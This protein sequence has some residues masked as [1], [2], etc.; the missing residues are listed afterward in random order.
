MCEANDTFREH[1]VKEG[2]QKVLYVQLMKALYGCVK[3]AL[4]WYRLYTEVLQ[5]MGFILNPYNQCVANKE[6][7]GSQCTVAFYVDDNKISHKDA[8]IVSDI[9]AVIEKRFGGLVV[10][11]GKEHEFLGMNIMLS[12]DKTVK[13][14]MKRYIDEAIS[15]YSDIVTRA[16]TTPAKKNLFCI[17][18]DS[19][20]LSNVAADKFHS[21]IAKLLYVSK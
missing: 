6:I 2:K 10:T 15:E 17:N 16:A 20:P 14:C 1:L 5:D 4:L 3:S 13:V 7:N 12:D 11:R 18:P 19:P 21:V 9:I 8:N